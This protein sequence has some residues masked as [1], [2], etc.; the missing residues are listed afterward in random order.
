MPGGFSF[1]FS[2]RL[3]KNYTKGRAIRL[4]IRFIPYLVKSTHISDPHSLY[5]CCA[6]SVPDPAFEMN[7]DPHL[8]LKMKPDAV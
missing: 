3:D 5:T 1:R 8:A 4:N 6:I 7:A 2:I